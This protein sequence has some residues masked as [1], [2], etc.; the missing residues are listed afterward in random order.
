MRPQW[1]TQPPEA[2]DKK[3]GAGRGEE[4]LGDPLGPHIYTL[5]L[6]DAEQP[7]PLGPALPRGLS[8]AGRLQGTRKGVVH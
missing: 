4:G 6:G 8:P 3:L 7:S 1:T 2:L 5:A